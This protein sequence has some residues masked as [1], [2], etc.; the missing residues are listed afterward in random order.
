[1][2]IISACLAG[3]DCK[4]NGGNNETAWVKN[5]IG[6]KKCVLVCPEDAG[7]LPTPRPPAERKGERV[8]DKEGNDVTEA[9]IFG[10][11]Q[12][13]VRAKKSSEI[14]ND[15]IELAILK[16]NS[17]SCGCGTIYDGSFSKKLIKG[18]GV[19]TELLK[20]KGIRVITEKDEDE[21]K[22]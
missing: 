18:D 8:V 9:F 10:A 15:E 17:P 11:E 21:I 5:L 16:S 20:K 7:N 12:S 22:R 1:M 4:Y 6:K 19:F 14:L 13:L 2:Y 3:R